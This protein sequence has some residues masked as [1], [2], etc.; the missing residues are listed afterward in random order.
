[1]KKTYE[2]PEIEIK[3]FLLTECILS[4]IESSVNS[5]IHDFEEPT[6]GIDDL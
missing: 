6:G 1:M 5:E 3:E 2:S 4:S